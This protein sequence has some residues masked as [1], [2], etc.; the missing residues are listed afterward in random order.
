MTV[1]AVLLRQ[2]LDHITAHPEQHDQ[3]HFA[4]RTD[5]GTAYCLAGHA[6]VLSGYRIAWEESLLNR[7]AFNAKLDDGSTAEIPDL[8]AELLGLEP[9][10]YDEE[11]PDLFDGGNSRADLWRMASELTDGAIPAEPPAVQ[12]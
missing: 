11:W 4:I 9:G 12:S 3:A 7:H 2:V 10:P 8:A 5:C 6:V 1:N